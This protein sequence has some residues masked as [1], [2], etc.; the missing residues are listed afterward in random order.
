MPSHELLWWQL[1]CLLTHLS[2]GMQTQALCLLSGH[3]LLAQQP[4]LSGTGPQPPASHA[5]AVWLS[6]TQSI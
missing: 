1:P 2:G 3:L 4:Q 6:Q 5:A